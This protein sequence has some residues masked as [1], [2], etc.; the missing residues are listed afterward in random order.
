MT[1]ERLVIVGAG[2]FG[3]ET[4]EIARQVRGPG[5]ALAMLDDQP[6]TAAL[7]MMQRSGITFLGPVAAWRPDPGDTCVLAVGEPQ[8]RERLAGLLADRVSFATLVHPDATLS[9]TAEL[10]P[11]V[12]VAPGARVST[13]ARLGPHVHV[14]QNVTVAHDVCVA[15]FARLNPAACVSGAVDIGAGALV[16]ANATVLQGLTVGAGAIVGAGAVVTTDVPAHATVKG[17]PAR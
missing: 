16:G 4:A 12:I 1:R 7:A 6:S 8:A 13:H 11:G 15:A 10:S 2:G 3:R 17:V 9:T 14:D 5:A